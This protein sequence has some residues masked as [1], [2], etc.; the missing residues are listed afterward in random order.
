MFLLLKRLGRL[1]AGALLMAALPGFGGEAVS[2]DLRSY[3]ADV[4]Q[5]HPDLKA[6]DARVAAAQAQADQPVAAGVQPRTRMSAAS[7]ARAS[8]SKPA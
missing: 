5:A 6:A 1:A 4:L 7:T 3:L 2:T 8:R